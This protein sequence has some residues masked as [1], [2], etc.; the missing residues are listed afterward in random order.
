MLI[1][2]VSGVC[3]CLGSEVSAFRVY[4]DPHLLISACW[5]LSL[6]VLGLRV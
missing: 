6:D 3:V 1:C 4:L 5:A 2:R